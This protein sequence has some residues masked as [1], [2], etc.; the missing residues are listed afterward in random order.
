MLNQTTVFKRLFFSIAIFLHQVK[1]LF[2]M[3]FN[4]PFYE[5]ESGNI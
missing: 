2:G 5:G 4:Q 1:Y 3:V